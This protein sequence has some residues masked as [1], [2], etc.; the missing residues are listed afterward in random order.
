MQEFKQVELGSKRAPITVQQHR[1]LLAVRAH[2]RTAKI[3]PTYAE[4]GAALGIGKSSAR[5]LV[6]TL[7]RKGLLERAPGRYRNLTVTSRGLKAAKQNSKE[8]AA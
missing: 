3:S 2:L 1:A 8:E 7:C 6:S 4:V 5:V